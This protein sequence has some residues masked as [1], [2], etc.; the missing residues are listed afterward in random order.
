M[1]G[2]GFIE[3]GILTE[4]ER[5]PLHSCLHRLQNLETLVTELYNKPATIPPAKDDMLLKSLNRNKSIEQDLQKTKKAL[6]TT[7]SK[8]V[9]LAKSLEHLKERDLS[10]ARWT[11][12]PI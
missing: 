11:F 8:Q 12:E 6:F 10:M 9:E 7:A 1:T 3:N 2:S 5:D 4:A